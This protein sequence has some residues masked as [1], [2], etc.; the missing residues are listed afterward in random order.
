[1]MS[2][3]RLLRRIS[4]LCLLLGLSSPTCATAASSNWDTMVWDQE[5][6]SSIVVDTD[7]DDV[8]DT[9]DNCPF[10]ANADQIDTDGDGIGDT[11]DNCAEIVNTNQLD[12]DKDNIGN[13]CDFCPDDADNDIDGDGICGDV[14]LC[15]A[16]SNDLDADS[17]GLADCLD[18]GDTDGDS[19]TDM[20]E[21]ACGS[22]P[23]DSLSRC[24]ASLPWLMLL[25]E[26]E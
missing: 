25:L 26:D 7:G 9:T 2:I 12:N 1:M 20:E 5:V 11:C 13:T 24:S 14:D 3:L 6:W 21:V 10:I 16:Y 22:D 8:A 23:T 17:D 19:F 18:E 15:P 4:I